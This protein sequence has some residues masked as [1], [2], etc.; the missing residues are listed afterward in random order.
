[1]YGSPI[2]TY[3]RNYKMNVAAS[4][5]VTDRKK[6]II[7]IASAV[8]YD[9]SSWTQFSTTAGTSASI[10]LSSLS[11][12]TS[13]TVK[14]RARRQYNQV[15]GTSDSSTVKTLGGAVVNSVNTVTADNAT[16][17]IT[18][19]VTVYEA[20]Y[21]NT[22]V[23]KNGGTTILT[24]SVLSWSKGTAN[25]SVTLSSAQRTTLLNWMA[26]MKSFTGTFA[27]SSFSGSTQIGS[28]SSKT[29]TVLT[30]ATK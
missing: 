3:I 15:Y 27:V 28:T 24:I 7:E 5:L 23:L 9:S 8:G 6:R 2:Y 12:N 16:V 4:M 19:N 25:R 22:L 13:Y 10:T 21:A 20:S 1:M 26:S 14:V 17:S 18:I 29:A 11:P 30:T